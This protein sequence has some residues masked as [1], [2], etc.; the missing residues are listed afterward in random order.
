MWHTPET[1]GTGFVFLSVTS[2]ANIYDD[3]KV[4]V[5]LKDTQDLLQLSP[6]DAIPF[7]KVH[8]AVDFRDLNLT[9]NDWNEPLASH[10]YQ[11]IYLLKW[12]FNNTSG[13]YYHVPTGLVISAFIMTFFFKCSKGLT[14]N[15]SNLNKIS[16]FTKAQ[17]L[18]ITYFC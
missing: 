4:P 11:L 3:V 16:F 8:Y 13:Y 2:K 10:Y 5:T 12:V 17:G 7:V 15:S 14:A 6:T 1:K 18:Q 9:K